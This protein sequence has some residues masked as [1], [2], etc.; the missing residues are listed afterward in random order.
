MFNKSSGLLILVVFASGCSDEQATLSMQQLEKQ[1]MLMESKPVRNMDF[2]QITR[3]GN[4]FNNNCAT[5]HGNAGQGA[6]NWQKKGTDGKPQ[7]PPL[8]GTGHAWHH[9]YVQLKRTIKQGT[10]NIGGSMPAWNEKLSE[11]DIDDVIAWFMSK[12]P[13]ELYLAWYKRNEKTKRGG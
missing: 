1:Q 4:I 2:S 12:W 6:V 8:N 11:Q 13:D 9:P 7:A 5:C 3:G 10:K